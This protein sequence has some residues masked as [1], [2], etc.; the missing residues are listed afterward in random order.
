MHILSVVYM[1]VFFVFFI[2]YKL[3]IT[4]L[5]GSNSSVCNNRR[6]II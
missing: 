3:D 1:V 6:Y 4:N 2:V 5:W